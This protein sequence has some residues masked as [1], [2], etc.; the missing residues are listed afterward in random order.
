MQSFQ[1]KV[2]R[3]GSSDFHVVMDEVIHAATS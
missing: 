3:K 1:V 2:N